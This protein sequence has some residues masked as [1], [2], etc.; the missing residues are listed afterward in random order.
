MSG[1]RGKATSAYTVIDHEFD[2]VVVG[3]GGAG[4]RAALGL[5]SAGF[6]TAYV[7]L[8][9]PA[10]RILPPTRREEAKL[11]PRRTDLRIHPCSWARQLIIPEHHP[12][13]K[14]ASPP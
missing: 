8:P 13:A 2:A 1:A 6:K 14:G 3:A 7:F 11:P 12:R 5:T 9:P 10:L 4:L